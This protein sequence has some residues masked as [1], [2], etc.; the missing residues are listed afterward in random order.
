M[1]MVLEK[2]IVPLGEWLRASIW[3]GGL[4]ILVVILGA[5]FVGFL[6]SALRHGPA[7]A[8]GRVWRAF[9]A[10]IVELLE[11]SPRRVYAMARLAFQ[12]SIRRWVLAVFAVFLLLL[13]FAALFLNRGATDHPA[14]LYLSF[15]ITATNYLLMLLAIFLS[16]FSLPAD[17]KNR[18]I[19]TV[20]T[21]PVRAW[22]LIIGRIL[23]FTAI[24]TMI[25]GLVAVSSYIFVIRGLNHRHV[26]LDRELLPPDNRLENA[27][28]ARRGLTSFDAFHRH[29]VVVYKDGSMEVLENLDHTHPILDPEGSGTGDQKTYGL[30]TPEGMLQA[31]IPVR[32]KLRFLDREGKETDKGINV[33]NEWTYRSYIEGGTGLS[34]AIWTFSGVNERRFGDYLPLEI[35]IRVFRTYKGIIDQGIAGKLEVVRPDGTLRSQ[36]IN[37]IAKDGMVDQHFIPRKLKTL[38]AQGNETEIDLYNDLV[39]DGK[40]EI[41]LRCLEN[42]QYFGVAQADAYLREADGSFLWNFVKG[43]LSLWFQMFLITCYGV[44]FSTFLNGPVAMLA[45]VAVMIIGFFPSFVQGVALG[46]LQGDVKGAITGGGPLESL[47]RIFRQMNQTLPLEGIGASIIHGIDSVVMFVLDRLTRLHIFPDFESFSTTNFVVYG[48]D[49]PG[50]L[51]AQ[52]FVICFAYF[53]LTSAVAYYCFKGREI[54]A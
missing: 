17:V 31:R 6:V 25:L 24:G 28:V 12:E 53:A 1:A 14:R 36:P 32:G 39:Q 44:M 37:F 18:T 54:A 16:T 8:F 46:T 2:D 50:A 19:F 48:F 27:N 9:I 43:Y 35:N 29:E 40:V 42:N 10:G 21:K 3:W 20:V 34:T 30:G 5:F 11:M 7:A 23:G 33:G 49:V 45:T 22:E 51:V 52:H 15:V 13:A 38:D 4:A 41:W 26:V 47:Y